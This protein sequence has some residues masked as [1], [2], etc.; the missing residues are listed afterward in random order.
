MRDG[1]KIIGV[2]DGSSGFTFR[3]SQK[4]NGGRNADLVEEFTNEL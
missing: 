4:G 2:L 3:V 1:G